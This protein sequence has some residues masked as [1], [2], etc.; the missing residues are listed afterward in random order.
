MT[1]TFNNLTNWDNKKRKEK[2]TSCLELEKNLQPLFKFKEIKTCKIGTEIASHDMAFFES[3][4][5]QTIF[6]LIPGNKEAELGYNK[7]DLSENI[8]SEIKKHNEALS[9]EN[10]L[11][12]HRKIHIKP[13]LTEVEARKF[14]IF[15][16]NSDEE[17][18]EQIC[19][20]NFRLPKSDE[21][22]YCCNGEASTFFRWGN[23]LPIKGDPLKSDNF[24]LH[25]QPNA[26]GLIFT[27]NPYDIELCQNYIYRNGDGG[28]SLCGGEDN[29][30]AWLPLASAY[31]HPETDEWDIE[32]IYIRRVYEIK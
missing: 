9:I 24:N 2:E 27:G 20:K 25:K 11:T 3:L 14:N 16:Y 4:P 19:G 30:L 15:D 8:L 26:F 32:D 12:A 21:W 13:L 31:Q 22:E 10:Y 29:F 7:K 5:D 1:K 6:V 18:I 28:E 17:M 23:S